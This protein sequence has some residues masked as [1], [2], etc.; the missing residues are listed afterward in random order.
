MGRSHSIR[1]GEAG[2]M[3]KQA[4]L[5]IDDNI[6]VLNAL[7]AELT[8]AIGNAYRIEIAQGGATA[9]TLTETLLDEGYEIPLVVADYMMPGLK[10]DELLQQI[11]LR[12]PTTLKILLTE[13]ADLKAI[14]NAISY[15]NL[16][17]YIAKPWQSE[18]L[19]FTFKEAIHNYRQQQELVQKNEQLQQMNQ[20]LQ[21][22]NS[23]QAK[24]IE[25][26]QKAEEKYRSLF[27]NALEGIFQTS[28]DGRF[29]SAN[30]ALAHNLGYDSPE[31]LMN[32]LTDMRTQLYAD[33]RCR[34]Q[35][36][37]LMQQHDRVSGFEAEGYRKDGSILWVSINARTVRDENGQLLYFQGFIQDI[38]E[39]KQAE[40]ILADYQQTLEQQVTERT[41]ALQQEITE[42]QRIEQALRQSEAQYRAMV[43]DQTE[44]ICRFLPNGI[45]TFVNGTYCRYFRQQPESLIGHT[46]TPMIPEADQYIPRQ[47][48]STLSRENPFITYEHR[49]ILPDGDVRWQ[50]WTDRAIF[51]E[52]GNFVEFHAVGRDITDRK[53]AEIALQESETR[54]RQLSRA[55]FEAI[56][57]TEAG[58]ILD[59]NQTFAHI[60]GYEPGEVIGMHTSN[61]VPLEFQNF[62][63]EKLQSR[64]EGPYECPCIRK[65]G[66][67][68]P[69]EVRARFISFEERVI[70]IAAIRDITERKQVE[71]ASVLEERN[72]MARE[73]HDTLAQS[74]AGIVI[75]LEAL[76]RM[77]TLLPEDAQLCL[78]QVYDL[79]Q[80]GLNEARR[81]V[82]ALRP[83]L[84]EEGDLHS[85]IAEFVTQINASAIP[86]SV[87]QRVGVP[88]ALPIDVENNLLR[89]CQEAITNAIKHADAQAIYVELAY[90]Q[91][92]CSLRVKDNGQGL[93]LS[94][95]LLTRGFGL[96]GME[97]RARGI[98]GTFNLY[99]Q[100]GQGTEVVVSIERS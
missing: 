93:E 54:F 89:I 72:R 1:A 78:I 86:S 21:A 18:D 52:E 81:S 83:Q 80:S 15:T 55:T 50:Q 67:T 74:F 31:Q 90:E 96:M 13:Q 8:D 11:H 10:G 69:A 27:E 30:P 36:V 37:A 16:Y 14:G 68:F 58:T 3:M 4:I 28:V 32:T 85:A 24:L 33:P 99:S 65:D 57:I 6:A 76:S 41:L 92:C 64:D 63:G 56:A 61:F 51:D 59:A 26:L 23:E 100:P 12:S 88:Y 20:T 38:S 84:L 70:K 82:K 49:V 47:Y 46:F 75:Q 2:G 48:F 77:S 98:G 71:A 7:Q 42:R 44:L 39:R 9:L 94:E 66:T 45:L 97:E 73:I 35:F 5:C 34:D 95:P 60:F 40:K 79:A 43:E 17:R 29:L 62:I 19:Q 91:T 87:Y 22:L 53:R 25:D